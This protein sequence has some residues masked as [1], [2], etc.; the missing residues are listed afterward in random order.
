MLPARAEARA[1]NSRCGPPGRDK[2]FA[3]ARAIPPFRRTKGGSAACSQ[4][5][6]PFASGDMA[7]P[8]AHFISFEVGYLINAF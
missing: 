5:L 7:A 4:L 1:A 2:A 6:A 3:A 8:I